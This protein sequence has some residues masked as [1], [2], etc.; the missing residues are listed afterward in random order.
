MEV[1]LIKPLVGK[2][3]LDNKWQQVEY[4]GLH[5]ACYACRGQG[6]LKD[7]S[8]IKMQDESGH[9]VGVVIMYARP[10]LNYIESPLW[11]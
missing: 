3:P 11:F 10:G 6:H 4:E 7:I 9:I 1:D 2:L 5:V 8:Q